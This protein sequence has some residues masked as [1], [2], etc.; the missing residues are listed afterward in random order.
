LYDVTSNAAFVCRRCP[1]YT[2][3]GWLSEWLA[4]PGLAYTVVEY[5]ASPG[6]SGVHVFAMK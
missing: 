5:D 3:R 2:V 1:L 6:S 4:G